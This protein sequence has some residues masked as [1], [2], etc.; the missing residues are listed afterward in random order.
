MSKCFWPNKSLPSFLLQALDLLL[1]YCEA[2]HGC[3]EHVDT[4]VPAA[5]RH[6]A[7]QRFSDRDRCAVGSHELHARS[8]LH[9]C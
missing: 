5:A 4:A 6:V 8:V 1:G 9:S 3:T 7:M 2:E